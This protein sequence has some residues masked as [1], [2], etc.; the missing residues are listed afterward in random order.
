MQFS[1]ILEAYPTR[2][3]SWE[4]LV[5]AS[6]HLVNNDPWM[7]PIGA[8]RKSVSLP[9]TIY[10]LHRYLVLILGRATEPDMSVKHCFIEWNFFDQASTLLR[11]MYAL[12]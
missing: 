9:A 10:E 8:V 4:G 12:L 6:S 3:E 2:K 1:R 11:A 7:V 5:K